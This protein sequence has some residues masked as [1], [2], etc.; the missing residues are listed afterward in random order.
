MWQFQDKYR[1]SVTSSESGFSHFSASS[2]S[3]SW[4]VCDLALLLA[5]RWPQLC[6]P[7]RYKQQKRNHF[8]LCDFGSAR[9][10]FSRSP[11]AD[12]LSTVFGPNA[13][14][15]YAYTSHL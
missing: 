10:A 1:D 14:Y 8:F 7:S 9:Q 11:S 12:F 5:A 13:S 3:G 6:I 15:A 4:L 2:S